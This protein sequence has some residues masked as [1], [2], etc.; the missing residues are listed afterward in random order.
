MTYELNVDR[1]YA[2]LGIFS[3]FVISHDIGMKI[4]IK[5][6]LMT[7]DFHVDRFYAE[8]GAFFCFRYFI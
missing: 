4:W 7:Q 1:F 6:N 5:L 8:L 2:Q 3:I